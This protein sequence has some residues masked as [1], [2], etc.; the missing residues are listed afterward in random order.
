[1]WLLGVT[2]LNKI[3]TAIPNAHIQRMYFN[4]LDKGLDQEQVAVWRD[5]LTKWEATRGMPG[6]RGIK[7][8][9]HP[10]VQRKS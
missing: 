2:L 10:R 4:E 3:Y 1:M 9:F 5:E 6:A 8:P 7:S